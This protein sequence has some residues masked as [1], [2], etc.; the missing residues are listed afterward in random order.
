MNSILLNSITFILLVN[1]HLQFNE[2]KLLSLFSGFVMLIFLS[3]DNLI[4]F[5]A[6]SPIVPYERRF[7]NL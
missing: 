4:E 6:C 3:W 2:V 5:A 7:L 1:C